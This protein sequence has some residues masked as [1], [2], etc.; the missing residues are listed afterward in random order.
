MERVAST[1]PLEP[2]P[3]MGKLVVPARIENLFEHMTEALCSC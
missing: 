1:L 2:A 3:F